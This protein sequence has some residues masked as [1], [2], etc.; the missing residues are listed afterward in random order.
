MVYGNFMRVVRV[1]IAGVVLVSAAAPRPASA[2]PAD[3]VFEGLTRP[4]RDVDLVMRVSGV[5]ARLPVKSG[6][7]VR[8]GDVI[9]ELKSELERQSLEIARLRSESD[10]EIIIAE[11]TRKLRETE[12][13]QLKELAAREAA[14][15]WEV[16]TT[17]VQVE[18]EQA[19]AETARFNKRLAEADHHREQLL[20]A[21]RTLVAPFDGVIL[22][23]MK[24]EGEGVADLEPIAVLV[25]LD[26]IWV[27]CNLPAD[28]FGRVHVGGVAGVRIVA[29]D[30][31]VDGSG[32]DPAA[33]AEVSRDGT[34]IAADPL[35]DAASNTFRVI[36]EVS[37]PDGAFA[38]GLVVRVRLNE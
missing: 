8:Q 34:I 7:A 10:H 19:R 26:P 38:A 13:S 30:P 24:E 5:L 23:T 14:S 6:Q 3:R 20:L 16:E 32:E 2:Q 29:A 35:V 15:K 1:L 33:A 27:E 18:I 28:L 9:A 31:A 25:R 11:K 36:F 17:G 4:S 37:N 21:E 22:R 12:L